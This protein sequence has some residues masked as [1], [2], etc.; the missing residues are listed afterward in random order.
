MNKPAHRIE[1]LEES[2]T[3][4]MA[5]ASRQLKAQGIDVISLSFGEPDFKTPQH[6]RDAAKNFLDEG[7]VYYTPVAGIPDLR[8]A[9]SEKFQRENNLSFSPDQVM[10]STGAKHSLMNLILT[11]VDVGDEV[12]IPT[13]YW[14]SYSEMVKLAEGVSVF[15]AGSATNQFKITAEQLE[16]AI[17]PKTRV[18]LF[19]SPCNPT[20]SVYSKEELHAFAKV[21]SKYPNIYVIAD[22]I[23]EHINYVSRHETIAQF[24]EIK[25]RVVVVNGVSKAFAMTGWRLGYMGGPKWIIDACDKLQSQFTSGANAI[26]QHAAI[27][28]LNSPMEATHA[29]TREFKDRRDRVYERLSKINGLKTNLP[30]GAFYFFPE[31]TYFFGKKTPDGM[32]INNGEDLCMYLLHSAHVAVVPGSAFGAEGFIRLSYA[33]SVEDLQKAVDRMQTALDKLN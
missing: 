13:P 19:S 21:L 22:E 6:I 18:L 10:V 29:M 33:A 16:Q 1:V 14:V 15:V 7:Y 2:Q 11:L 5:K 23:Y 12:V 4:A 27:A 17:T 8:K 25:D 32:L 9:I 24:D 26:A 31:V 30:D 20:G 3:I 28:A